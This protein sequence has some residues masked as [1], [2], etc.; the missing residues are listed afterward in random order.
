MHNALTN[1]HFVARIFS[2]K[3]ANFVA[4]IFY[5]CHH[6]PFQNSGAGSATERIMYASHPMNQITVQAVMANVREAVIFTHLP[7][8]STYI[9]FP[10]MGK[11]GACRVFRLSE[12]SLG[13]TNES[14]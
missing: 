13:S 11:Y 9:W 3:G 7:H 10:E 8:T 6:L 2:S 12:Y 14:A 1:K 5:L 4:R